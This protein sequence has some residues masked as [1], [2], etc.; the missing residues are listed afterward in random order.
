VS[1]DASQK[2]LANFREANQSEDRDTSEVRARAVGVLIAV[3]S[4]STSR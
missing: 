4:T 3:G 2:K 1:W